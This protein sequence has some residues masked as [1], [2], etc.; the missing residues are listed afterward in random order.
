MAGRGDT[1]SVIKRSGSLLRLM[2]L[3]PQ[4]L[5]EEHYHCLPLQTGPLRKGEMQDL[6]GQKGRKPTSVGIQAPAFTPFNKKKCGHHGS[7]WMKVSRWGWEHPGSGCGPQEALVLTAAVCGEEM[8]QQE[9]RA[10]HAALWDEAARSITACCMDHMTQT[11]SYISSS[12]TTSTASLHG[13]ETWQHIGPDMAKRVR[14]AH[15][16]SHPHPTQPPFSRDFLAQRTPFGHFAFRVMSDLYS[17]PTCIA[18]VY[19]CNILK[20]SNIPYLGGSLEGE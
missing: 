9:G 6:G 20:Y 12:L 19:F 16:H 3:K 5:K 14:W 7:G 13:L 2:I 1:I 18:F 8:V 17:S 10:P 11:I 4:L 15:Q